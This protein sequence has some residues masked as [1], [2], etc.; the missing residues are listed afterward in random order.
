MSP[1]PVL[2]MTQSLD[3]GGSE[4]QMTQ[5]ARSLDRTRFT[6][7]VGC[8]VLGGVREAELRAAGIPI[9]RFPVTSF[10]DL[11]AA[12]GARQMRHYLRDHRISLVHSFDTPSN[13]FAALW[14]RAAGMTTLLT[15][16]RAHRELVTPTIRHLLR[17]TDRRAHGVVVNCEFLRRHLTEEEDVPPEHIHLCYNGVDLDEFHPQPRPPS[18]G[19]RIGT[20]CSVRSEKGLDTLMEAFAALSRTYSSARL[21]IVG[22]GPSVASL[23][24]LAQQ[25]G[26]D[27]RVGFEPGTS[28]VVNWLHEFDIFVL[29]SRSEAFSN[30]LMEAMVCGCSVVA[31]SVGGNPELVNQDRGL[32]F[33][34][35]DPLALE[36]SLRWMIEHPAERLQLA[37]AATAF[38]REKL[39]LT[40]SARR[41]EQ[42]YQQFLPGPTT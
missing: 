10:R 38:I 30:S 7:H 16:Q 1:Q 35:G 19:W 18:E 31:S 11:S 36:N 25:L 6:P 28:K 42:I 37:S 34:A 20:I 22:H 33:P 17:V 41:M 40:A 2:L 9:V 32:L 4:R 21:T 39:S 27:R 8:F 3:L 23:Q 12:I 26:I 5:I 24:A 15:S 13:I 29:P 14:A